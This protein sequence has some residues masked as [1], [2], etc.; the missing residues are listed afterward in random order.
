MKKYLKLGLIT[1]AGIVGTMVLLVV[2]WFASGLAELIIVNTRYPSSSEYYEMA[3]SRI[4]IGD[5]RDDA[6]RALSD[7]WYHG[8][9]DDPSN[10]ELFMKDVFFYGP[11]NRPEYARMIVVRSEPIDG[12]L[13]VSDIGT[14]ESYQLPTYAECIPPEFLESD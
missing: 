4:K 10:P 8:E 2:V 6:V 5:R 11:P 12:I 3:C 9:C 14:A 13:I 7:A 1:F